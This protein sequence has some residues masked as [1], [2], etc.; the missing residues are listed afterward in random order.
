MSGISGVYNYL[1]KFID[2]KSILEKIVKLQHA[3]GPDDQ[4]IWISKCKKIS[5]GHNRLAII[6][7][8]K[9]GKQPFVSNDGNLVITFN[10]EIYNYKEIKKLITNERFTYEF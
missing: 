7:L 5:L 1:E 2:A 10:G 4:G 3:R 8:T 6:D 9:K